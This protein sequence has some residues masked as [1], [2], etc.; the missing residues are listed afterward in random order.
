MVLIEVNI[1]W[2]AFIIM[3]K[4]YEL[5]HSVR[6]FIKFSIQSGELHFLTDLVTFI[7]QFHLESK[8]NSCT[9]NFQTLA[10]IHQQVMQLL[11]GLFFT[12]KKKLVRYILENLLLCSHFRIRIHFT[13]WIVRTDSWKIARIAE[14]KIGKKQLF[15]LINRLIVS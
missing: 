5:S 2:P 11:Y 10:V 7:F 13:N 4:L 1:A 12:N 15:R 6:T 9:L 14:L 3:K 8:W